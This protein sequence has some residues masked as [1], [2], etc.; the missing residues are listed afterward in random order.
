MR[1]LLNLVL[2][3]VLACLLL[4]SVFAGMRA[5]MVRAD[6]EVYIAPEACPTKVV[7]G[8]CT[9]TGDES[10]DF[11]SGDRIIKLRE[12]SVL[13]VPQKYIRGASWK[14]G[15]VYYKLEPVAFLGSAG[16]V[17]LLLAALWHVNKPRGPR[18]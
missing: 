6:A 16:R 7:G 11:V 2:S 9:V 12:G 18:A 13:Y 15:N 17:L 4:N 10:E 5:S 1:T 8:V 3:L 14:S